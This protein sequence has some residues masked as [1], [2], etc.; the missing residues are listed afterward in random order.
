MDQNGDWSLSP[1]FDVNWSYNPDGAWTSSHQMTVNG[2]R[3]D[4]DIE[5]LEACAEVGMMKRGRAREIL[6]EVQESVGRWPEFAAEAG[7]PEEVTERIA[8][9]HRHLQAARRQRV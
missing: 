9:T 1:A 7:L 3:D 5:D 6:A 8:E 4:F 2:K